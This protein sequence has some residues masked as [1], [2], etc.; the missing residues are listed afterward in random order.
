METIGNITFE[1]VAN[2]A[3]N[4][5]LG[6]PYDNPGQ[7]KKFCYKF[8]MSDTRVTDRNYFVT[9]E[10]LEQLVDEYFNL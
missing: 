6:E 9:E 2:I 4:F 3:D 1:R 7:L 5:C 8:I 10:L